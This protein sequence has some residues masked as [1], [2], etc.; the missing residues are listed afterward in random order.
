MLAHQPCYNASTR[1]ENNLSKNNGNG[2]H[3]DQQNPSDD[4]DFERYVIP[5]NTETHDSVDPLTEKTQ[6]V[7]IEPD[8]LE[9]GFID[10]HADDDLFDP[11]PVPE[12]SYDDIIA[13]ALRPSTEDEV[14]NE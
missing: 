7:T 4:A 5:A 11:F 9:A 1:G 10:P 3:N 2:H 13:A 8:L 14:G 12:T 6:S